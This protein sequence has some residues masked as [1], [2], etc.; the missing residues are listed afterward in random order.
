M[1]PRNSQYEENIYLKLTSTKEIE[2][3]TTLKAHTTTSLAEEQQD[4]A[5]LANVITMMTEQLKIHEA[6]KGKTKAKELDTFNG[7]DC[8]EQGYTFPF[9]S[10]FPTDYTRLASCSLFLSHVQLLLP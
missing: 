7:S 8:Y 9:A 4:T 6:K 2:E 5:N 10:P 1:V 3:V